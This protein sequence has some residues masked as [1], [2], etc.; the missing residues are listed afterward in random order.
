MSLGR[1]IFLEE[2][3]SVRCAWLGS[4]SAGVVQ[5]RGDFEVRARGARRVGYSPINLGEPVVGATATEPSGCR[6]RCVRVEERGGCVCF[7]R[8]DGFTHLAVDRRGLPNEPDDGFVGVARKIRSF[9]KDQ[10]ARPCGGGT[11]RLPA[12]SPGFRI[13]GAVARFPATALPGDAGLAARR[14]DGGLAQDLSRLPTLRRRVASSSGATGIRHGD[15][16]VTL[17]EVGGR[18]SRA[19]FAR[20]RYP[21]SGRGSDARRCARVGFRLHRVRGGCDRAVTVSAGFA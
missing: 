13:D 3:Q 6:K 20:P 21:W 9:G 11:A 14:T 8:K 19:C 10:S 18:W 17:A 4:C 2:S 7:T 5:E 1:I 16:L 12:K 15:F